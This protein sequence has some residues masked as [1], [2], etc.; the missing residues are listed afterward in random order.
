ME[1]HTSTIFAWKQVAALQVR[2]RR[3]VHHHDVVVEAAGPPKGK[4]I[5]FWAK[6]LIEYP[7]V[8]MST[9]TALQVTSVD[10]REWIWTSLKERIISLA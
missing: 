7:T 4:T 2:D 8:F 1:E 10:C 3:R 5:S 6:W 9:L